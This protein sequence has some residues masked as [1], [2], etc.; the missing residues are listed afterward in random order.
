MPTGAAREPTAAF[1]TSSTEAGSFGTLLCSIPSNE[2]ASQASIVA[3]RS[4]AKGVF[5]RPVFMVGV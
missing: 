3:S 2:A 1:E 5:L 4:R